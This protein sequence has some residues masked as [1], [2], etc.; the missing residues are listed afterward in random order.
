MGE[1]IMH[2]PLLPMMMQRPNHRPAGGLLMPHDCKIDLAGKGFE[3]ADETTTDGNCGIH[4]FALGLLDAA[5]RDK[6]LAN[7]SQL[8]QVRKLKTEVKEMIAHIRRAASKWMQ[9]NVAT[10]VWDGMTFKEVAVAMAG[11]PGRNF[12]D[13][14][15]VAKKRQ[16]M[17]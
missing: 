15:N 8:K 4:A 6:I 14:C 11:R 2:P 1:T 10:V 17:D 9:T 7:T 12:G 13:Q 16:R 5:K 3:V